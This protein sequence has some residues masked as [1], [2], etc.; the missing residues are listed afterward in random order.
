MPTTT[1][2][3]QTIVSDAL[4]AS[5]DEVINSV[6]H[7]TRYPFLLD[8]KLGDANAEPMP[9]TVI[10]DDYDTPL[11]SIGNKMTRIKTALVRADQQRGGPL[12]QIA[13]RANDVMA[14]AAII[15]LHNRRP[16]LYSENTISTFIKLSCAKPNHSP[17]IRAAGH[18]TPPPV[19][20]RDHHVDP[21]V[22]DIA[23]HLARSPEPQ[24]IEQIRQALRDR[25]ADL[26]K[27]PQL[28]LT[29]LIRRVA[30]IRPD[31]HGRYHFDENW[32]RFLS[33]QQL[34][35]DTVLRILTREREPRTTTYLVD[36]TEHLIRHLLP[37][38]YN[39]TNAVRNSVYTSELIEWHGP[40]TFRLVERAS[41]P[42]P[43]Q[44]VR[45]RGKTGKHIH[46]FLT[47]N[48]PAHTEDIIQHMQETFS[49]KETTI[50]D[51]IYR[52]TG[53]QFLR[54]G[55]RRVAANPVLPEHNP[56]TPTLVI[57]PD[58]SLHRPA[59][60]L[61]ESEL[62]WLTLYVRGLN[63]LTPP[64]P[65]R[66]AITGPRAAGF[67]HEGDTLEITVV[68]KPDQPPDL[69]VQ[70]EEVAAAATQAAPSVQPNISI[71]SP[72]QWE[73]QQASERPGAHHNIWLAPDGT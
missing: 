5:A 67:T 61:R 40:S 53:D 19:V 70:L 10:A 47:D 21:I 20:P 49:T 63:E 18:V 56:D 57:V 29:L 27:W 32:S 12:A 60:V 65:C 48:G 39:I 54:L 30:D 28:D 50:R 15:N 13:E 33:G 24:S 23:T 42:R 16:P 43:Q 38:G 25:Q 58:E 72:R 41:S 4:A 37:D 6:R 22:A 17:I 2:R 1:N 44:G 68:A 34:V 35:T 36:E 9:D 62:A 52:D 64:L 8:A 59:P 73:R 45:R 11:N 71:V 46:A 26:D 31:G 14:R 55:D 69:K 7:N 51:A 66:V 3:T